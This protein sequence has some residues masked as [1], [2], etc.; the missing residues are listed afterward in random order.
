V[1]AREDLDAQ[2][3]FWVIVCRRHCFG[4]KEGL[5]EISVGRFEFNSEASESRI[6]TAGLVFGGSTSRF[7]LLV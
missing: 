3:D 1:P 4:N 7:F 6:I 5:K 2:L